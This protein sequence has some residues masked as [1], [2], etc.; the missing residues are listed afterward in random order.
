MLTSFSNNPHS[1]SVLDASVNLADIPSI[2]LLGWFA[3]MTAGTLIACE[4]KE[5]STGTRLQ[6]QT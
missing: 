4:A 1:T 5:K 6:E 2:A 3:T